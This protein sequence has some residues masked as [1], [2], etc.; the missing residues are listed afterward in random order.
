MPQS[1]P[2]TYVGLLA[3]LIGVGLFLL[4]SPAVEQ[5]AHLRKIAAGGPVEVTTALRHLCWLR[6]GVTS[7]NDLLAELTLERRLAVLAAAHEIGCVDELAPTHQA[8][9]ALA[10]QGV[11]RGVG[12]AEQ[13]VDPAIDLLE[14]P[15]PAVADRALAALLILEPRW[16]DPQR[17][18]IDQWRKV[19]STPPVES[20]AVDMGFPPEQAA[21]AGGSDAATVD[22][23]ATTRDMTGGL[24]PALTPPTL[25]APPM[26][27]LY[28]SPP[29]AAPAGADAGVSAVDAGGAHD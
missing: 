6:P 20:T 5:E 10:Y 8:L 16:T 17:A 28:R 11:D 9:H 21:D 24:V 2:R 19:L 4:V 14:S 27:V 18:K 22:A 15:D 29:S 25:Q 7:L 3:V 13:A 26:A 23:A 12:F 1:K